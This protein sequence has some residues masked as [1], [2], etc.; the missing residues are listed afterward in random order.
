V[1]VS[2]STV[3]SD[4]GGTVSD[5]IGVGGFVPL[6][7]QDGEVGCVPYRY[8]IKAVNRDGTASRFGSGARDVALVFRGDSRRSS[9]ICRKREGVGG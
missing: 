8:R 9:I 5:G 3:K 7:R 4:A 2:T 6:I 1:A